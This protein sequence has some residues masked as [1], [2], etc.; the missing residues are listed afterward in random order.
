VKLPPLFPLPNLPA[1]KL[2]HLPAPPRAIHLPPSLSWR[3][4]ASWPLAAAEAEEDRPQ[5]RNCNSDRAPVVRLQPSKSSSNRP[6]GG[7][8]QR[9]R[10]PPSANRPF[11]ISTIAVVPPSP[12]STAAR[13]APPR[14]HYRRPYGRDPPRGRDRQPCGRDPPRGAAAA[15]RAGELRRGAAA[16]VGI[17]IIS[18]A[19]ASAG[20]NHLRRCEPLAEIRWWWKKRGE[21][22]HSVSGNADWA[23]T[24]ALGKPA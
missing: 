15:D 3:T 7:W 17:V 9:V 16:A 11:P 21:G 6:R 4:T 5:R 2:G 20:A 24:F 23:P 8:W 22:D 18:H 13:R 1:G 10:A 19:G 14:A 12:S